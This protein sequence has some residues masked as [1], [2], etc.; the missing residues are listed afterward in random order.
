MMHHMPFFILRIAGAD[1]RGERL[2]AGIVAFP[3]GAAPIVRLVNNA[4]RLRAVNPA[5]AIADLSE[6][7]Q[8]LQDA[9]GGA[10]G[11]A[12]YALLRMIIRPLE[13]DN[14]PSV[15]YVTLDEAAQEV[16]ALF[17][18]LVS[19][20]PAIRRPR[21]AAHRGS[22]LEKEIRNT[23]KDARLY[24]SRVE[25][26]SKKRVVGGYPIDPS[27][28]LYTDFAFMNG[29]IHVVET[30][31]L[32]G[33]EHLSASHRGVAAFKG[34][35]LDEAK[36]R[37]KDGKRIAVV[38]ASDYNVARPAFKLMERY[39]DELWDI[40]VQTDRQQFWRFIADAL[41]VDADALPLDG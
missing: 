21:T 23:L 16:D 40:G 9:L 18:R 36:D 27:A 39:A 28:D 4:A 30:L 35:T 26:L 22:Q 24:S 32:R 8:Q 29:A 38:S 3:E 10:R 5:F 37:L 33:V 15:A 41:H 1:V 34:V 12:R 31:D 19:P 11:E 6:W 7:P 2:N 25:D 17:D 13:I 20:P 14:E